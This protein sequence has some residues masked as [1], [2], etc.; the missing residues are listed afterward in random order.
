MDPNGVIISSVVSPK[1]IEF[2][3][4]LCKTLK[5]KANVNNI[6]QILAGTKL[7]LPPESAHIKKIGVFKRRPGVFTFWIENSAVI[8]EDNFFHVYPMK[9]PQLSKSRGLSNI[10]DL[11]MPIYS[12]NLR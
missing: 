4:L 3:S 11:A 6:C 9:D 2:F 1:E 8:T 12:L 7:D 10:V 5:K